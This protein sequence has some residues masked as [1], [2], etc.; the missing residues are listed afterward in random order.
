MR[1]LFV[2][3]LSILMLGTTVAVQAATTETLSPT[4]GHPSTVVSLSGAGFGASEAVDVYFDTVDTLLLVS[5]NTGT[6]SGSITI[7]ASALPGL[8]YITAVGRRT[9][10]AAQTTFDVGTPW[11]QFGYGAAHAALNPFE[12][13]LSAATVAS[14]G[15]EWINPGGSMGS[16]GATVAVNFG[17]AYV[18]T[19][20]GI[21][22]L[23]TSTGNVLWSSAAPGVVTAAPTLSGGVVYVSSNSNKTIFA[24]NPLNGTVI[25]SAVLDNSSVSSPAVAN[26]IIYVGCFDS[27]V[28]ALSASTGRT[29]W[30][31]TT[32]AYVNTTPTVVNGVLY[33]GSRDG[34][35]YALNATS[36]ALLWKYTTGG[37]IET[38]P[39]VANGVVYVGS[40]DFNVYA[41]EA[42][43]S[44]PGTLL[45]KYTTGADVF[46]S[47]AVANG[48]VYV[49]SDDGTF[50]ALDA[51]AGSLNWSI[52]T[53]GGVFGNGARSA[54]VAN[55]VVYFTSIDN[56]FYAVDIYGDIL[57]TAVTG[58]TYLGSP[59]I[60][61]GVAYIPALGGS[62]YAFALP[63]NLNGNA[64]RLNA[65]PRPASLHPNLR[66]RVSP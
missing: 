20:T 24:L 2:V 39:A 26:G 17:T 1:A 4:L 47:P 22:A 53:G 41:I 40:D 64:V 15:P 49:G 32:G 45:W 16:T 63:P 46:A 54:A 44:A 50:Y 19:H 34:N 65:P 5:S 61:D 57:A 25:W 8:Q 10:D 23:S 38:T 29:V 13:V 43:G 55:G 58:P 6:I 35:L 9:G 60:S 7:P 12:N 48:T 31:Y 56:T 37:P 51:H 3:W 36:G 59:T 62:I 33:L 42:Q 21:E 30:T 14:I 52:A 28:Y 11:T 18:A 66:L 27:K